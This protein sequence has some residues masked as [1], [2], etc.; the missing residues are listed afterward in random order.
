MLLSEGGEKEIDAGFLGVLGAL[1]IIA[2]AIADI[3]WP[4]CE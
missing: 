2:A 1:E 3:A 4:T